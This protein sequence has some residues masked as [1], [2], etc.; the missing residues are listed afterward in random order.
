MAVPRVT[1]TGKSAPRV[2]A[3]V[4]PRH[5]PS[6]GDRSRDRPPFHEPPRVRGDHGERRPLV[7][8]RRDRVGADREQPGSP[9]AGEET[10]DPS[11]APLHDLKGELLG[12]ARDL[13]LEAPGNP[14]LG[15][16]REALPLRV[17]VRPAPLALPGEIDLPR[18]RSRPPSAGPRTRRRSPSASVRLLRSRRRSGQAACFRAGLLLGL[19]VVFVSYCHGLHV[20]SFVLS[21]SASLA[22][23]ARPAQD[24]GASA[25]RSFAARA[26]SRRACSIT[27]DSLERK[28]SGPLL[29]RARLL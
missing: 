29:D 15:G 13:R 24:G 11:V 19:L 27:L 7:Q 17:E 14:A 5:S 16:L 18:A 6:L 1:P 23:L 3:G 20:C 22:R 26:A 9:G 10:R 2:C 12:G 25:N 21:R 8:C 28:C 4:L